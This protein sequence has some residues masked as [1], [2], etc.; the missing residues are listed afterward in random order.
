MIGRLLAH[1]RTVAVVAVAAYLV[2]GL[3]FIGTEQ[4]GLVSVFGA[5]RARPSEPGLHWTW[6]W[7]IGRVVKLKARET[8]RLTVGYEMPERVL[9]RQSDVDIV[10]FMTGDRN[11]LH[12]RIVVQY[13][14]RDPI[15]YLT[16]ARDVKNL[17]ASSAETALT[18]V[19]VERLVDDVL[20]TGKLAV[21]TDVQ[22]RC[23]S[24][25]DRYGCG[26]SVLGVN[27]E[28][29]SPPPEVVEAFRDVAS[30]R[31][32]RDRIV[33]QAQ[34]YANETLALA[35]GEAARQTSE[36]G[37]YHDRVIAA[38]EGEAARFSSLAA[39]YRRTPAETATRLYLE[40]L[41]EVFPKLQVNVV[42]SDEIELDV[43]RP[44]K[45]PKVDN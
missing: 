9:E 3:Y 30:A 38:A 14:I 16:K 6:P 23:Q 20:T 7:P 13:V 41:E 25:L 43:I 15:A 31:E 29:I 35:R 21:Q 2:S 39:E 8:K 18:G 19:V 24:A 11:I 36:A 45:A 33:R 37:A 34:S 22:A 40:T 4:Q 1:R 44:K 17:I 28:S 12:V 42:D 5:F 32:D 26:V 10:Q 27:I